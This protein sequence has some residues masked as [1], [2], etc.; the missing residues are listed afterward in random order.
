MLAD[1]EKRDTYVNPFPEDIDDAAFMDSSREESEA[2]EEED[3]K[4]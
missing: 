1:S 3:K 2:S 4:G